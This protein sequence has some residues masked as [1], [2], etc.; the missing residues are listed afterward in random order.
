MF[1][2]EDTLKDVTLNLAH[3]LRLVDA[4]ELSPEDFAEKMFEF[5]KAIA[6]GE[7]DTLLAN[8]EFGKFLKTLVDFKDN[9]AY[10][11]LFMHNIAHEHAIIARSNNQQVSDIYKIWG[12]TD[13]TEKSFQSIF[14]R[15]VF[16]MERF[17][18]PKANMIGV[19]V[20][21]AYAKRGYRVAQK[22]CDQLNSYY[23]EH[24]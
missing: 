17:F 7:E 20:L 3:I 14:D 6:S 4:R 5:A 12:D 18:N 15:A 9:K 13:V 21:K 10:A 22:Y 16:S 1:R 8:L 24:N 23:P 2:S 11:D 19:A